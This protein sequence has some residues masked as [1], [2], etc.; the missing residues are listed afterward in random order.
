MSLSRIDPNLHRRPT[1]PHPVQDLRPSLRGLLSSSQSSLLVGAP[2]PTLNEKEKKVIRDAF[3]L[4]DTDGD[5]SVTSVELKHVMETL[6]NTSMDDQELE[7]MVSVR[8]RERDT[9]LYANVAHTHVCHTIH[10]KHTYTL[11]THT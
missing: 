5:G 8:R 7:A 4:F 2:P 3:N 1:S 9:N 10:T 11:S 6:F